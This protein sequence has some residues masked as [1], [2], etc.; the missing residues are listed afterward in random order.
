MKFAYE[1]GLFNGVSEDS[2]APEMTMSR[3]MMVQVLYN[4]AGKPSANSAGFSDVDSNSWYFDAVSWAAQNGIVSG[5]GDNLFA[6][7]NDITREQMAVILFNY[8]KS[9]GIE[10]SFVR[11]VVPFADAEEIS[12]WAIEAL[13]AMYAAGILSGKGDGI[14]DPKSTATRAEVATMFMNFLNAIK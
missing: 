13:D 12:S 4:L 2:F 8:A 7:D 5:I 10:L 6:P 11:D 14:F 3:A 9:T 1:N